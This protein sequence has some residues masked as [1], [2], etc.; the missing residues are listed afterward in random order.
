MSEPVR[1]G[2][3][4]DEPE[5]RARIVEAC[6]RMEEIFESGSYPKITVRRHWSKHNPVISGEIAR[7]LA[8]RWYLSRELLKLARKGAEIHVEASRGRVDLADPSL[9]AQIDES[10]LDITRKKLFLFGPE[11]PGRMSRPVKPLSLQAAAR[12]WRSGA[13]SS[14]KKGAARCRFPC[15]R[16]TGR[17]GC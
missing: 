15:R 14:R 13:R 17:V 11:R 1:I 3:G 7:P 5:L 9:L 4:L 12:A 8:Y 2:S 6:D 10:D 16:R